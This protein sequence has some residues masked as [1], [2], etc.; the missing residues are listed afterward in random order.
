[1]VGKEFGTLEEFIEYVEE[2]M[3]Y[4]LEKNNSVDLKLK[5]VDRRGSL[6]I[7]MYTIEK[8]N[9]IVIVDEQPIPKP[10]ALAD[11]QFY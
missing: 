10:I 11:E 9:K 5:F 2:K 3:G 8:N 4:K 1:M 6:K 7:Y